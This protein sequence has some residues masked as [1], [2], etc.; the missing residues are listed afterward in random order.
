MNAGVPLHQNGRYK[1]LILRQADRTASTAIL[2]AEVGNQSDPLTDTWL[3]AS[4]AFE[5]AAFLFIE[6]SHRRL[7]RFPGL[8]KY[9][10]PDSC[11]FRMCYRFLLPRYIHKCQ[12]VVYD[13]PKV[14]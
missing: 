12:T 5:I 3:A 6:R 7:L 11:I 14:M 10:Y 1:L 2:S 8:S 4:H 13:S 9:L